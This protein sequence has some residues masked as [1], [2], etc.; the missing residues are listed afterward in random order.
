MIASA[1]PFHDFVASQ[2]PQPPLRAAISAH[3][4]QA[5]AACV[6]DLAAAATLPAEDVEQARLTAIALIEGLRAKGSGGIAQGL[7][8]A[9][10][11]S[12]RKAWR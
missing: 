10:D 6:S 7:L 12:G 4:R 8:R 3:Y 1:L 2:R 9:Y 5:E 11:L